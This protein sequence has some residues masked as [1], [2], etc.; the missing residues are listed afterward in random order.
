MISKYEQATT[1]R[2]RGVLGT[3]TDRLIAGQ[4]FGQSIGGGISESFKA[5]TTGL[6]EKF[7]PLNIAKMLSGNFG[8]AFLGKMTGRSSEDMQYFFNKGRKKGE[9]PYSFSQNIPFL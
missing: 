5:K 8:M 6:K 2:K 3:I 7:D 1:T 9:K 4:G